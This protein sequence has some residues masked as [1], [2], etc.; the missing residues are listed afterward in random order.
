MSFRFP[1]LLLQEQLSD[2]I[3][4]LSEFIN[5]IKGKPTLYNLNELSKGINDIKDSLD[6]EIQNK[7][8]D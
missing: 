6:N 1:F 4:F 7:K 8:N 2:S 3:T 5:V